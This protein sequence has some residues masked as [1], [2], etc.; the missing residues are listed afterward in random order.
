MKKKYIL[1]IDTSNYTTSAALTD[2][3]GRVVSEKAVLL[4]VKQGERGLRQSDALFKHIEIIPEIISTVA[5]SAGTDYSPS[6]IAAVSFSSRPRP[7]EGSYMPVFKAGECVGRSI[8]DILDVPFYDF[9]HQEG[10]IEAVKHFSD[11]ADRKRILSWHLSGG[12]CEL[13]I[14]DEKETSGYN[15]EIYASTGDIS[16]G[17]LF[18]RIGVRLG[19]D[20][21]S[22][23]YLDEIA[24]SEGERT[25]LLKPVFVRNNCINL[26]GMESQCM[27][28]FDSSNVDTDGLIREVFKKVSD[29]L[30]KMTENAARET[31]IKDVIF[32][33]GVSSSRYLRNALNE[34]FAGKDV[35][36]IFGNS[37]YS[38]DNAVGTA[39]LGGKMVWPENR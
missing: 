12:T 21:P 38:T 27:R 16:F 34:Y 35:N 26:S 7:V 29:C 5:G 2:L 20:F 15:I 39:L 13:L 33:G 11:A 23:R 3:K 25:S 31:G 17:Q 24:L 8:A 36:V 30:L 19:M 9:S 14:A 6:M 32:A 4:K 18:D 37:S 10:H 28:L 22:G 1:G